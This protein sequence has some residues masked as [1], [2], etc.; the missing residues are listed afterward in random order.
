MKLY[1]LAENS[2][3]SSTLLLPW[4]SI[5]LVLFVCFNKGEMK[6]QTAAQVQKVQLLWLLRDVYLQHPLGCPGRRCK[7]KAPRDP[8]Q[9][10]KIEQWPNYHAKIG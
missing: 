1:D 3:F 8:A 7:K 9:L 10:P 4:Y 2:L 5:I 6:P